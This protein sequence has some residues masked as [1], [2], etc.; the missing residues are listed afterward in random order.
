MKTHRPNMA[1]SLAVLIPL[2]V[3]SFAIAQD[4]SKR[5]LETPLEKLVQVPAGAQLDP[6]IL[7]GIPNLSKLAI[8]TPLETVLVPSDNFK[9]RGKGDIELP[10][11]TLLKLQSSEP[12]LPSTSPKTS[13]NPEVKP[14]DV[15][16]HAD[17]ATA[18]LRSKSSGKPVLLFQLM[19]ELDQQFT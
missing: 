1:F 6:N 3:T 2:T 7:L 11:E 8:E 16:W 13:D 4:M 14:G 10:I 15:N 9:Y 17:F 5:V 19:G 12:T 18:C